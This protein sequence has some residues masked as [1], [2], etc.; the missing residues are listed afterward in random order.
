MFQHRSSLSV[1][2]SFKSE[3]LRR[4]HAAGI[5]RSLLDISDS[6]SNGSFKCKSDQDQERVSKKRSQFWIP[7]PY[8]P[9]Y[10]KEVKAALSRI[11]GL[12]S[13]QELSCH[14]LGKVSSLGAAWRLDSQP[15]ASIA[16][17]F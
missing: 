16:R 9:M 7:L 3:V 8:H 11:S 2:R 12:S 6:Q 14:V 15:I 1:G 4:L 10:S 13:F 5:D 17:K